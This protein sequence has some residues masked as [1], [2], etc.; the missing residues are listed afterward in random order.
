MF[1]LLQASFGPAESTGERSG[2]A[3]RSEWWEAPS[4]RG[5]CDARGL[6]QAKGV[7][8]GLTPGSMGPFFGVAS[9]VWVFPSRASFWPAMDALPRTLFC[10]ANG[11]ASGRP[12]EDEFPEGP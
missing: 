10:D 9:C 3:A 5:P 8:W 12:S 7:Y 6:G 11:V 4:G 2:P 1:Y